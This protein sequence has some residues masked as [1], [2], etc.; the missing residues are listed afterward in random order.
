MFAMQGDLWHEANL[1]T[2]SSEDTTRSRDSK[3]NKKKKK[4]DRK[5]NCQNDT[6]AYILKDSDN[7][8]KRS[9]WD[10]CMEKVSIYLDHIAGALVLLN[11]VL[12]MLQL[13]IEGRQLAFELKVHPERQNFDAVLPVFQVMDSVFVFIFLAELLIRIVLERW[14]FVKDSLS[15]RV[16]HCRLICKHYTSSAKRPHLL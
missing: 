10:V 5:T 2:N 3:G 7:G 12:L 15:A 11:S 16:R 9:R 13:E 4:K 6:V 8:K 1:S 14:K